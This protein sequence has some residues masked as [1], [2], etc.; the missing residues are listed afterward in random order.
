MHFHVDELEIETGQNWKGDRC[1]VV[2]RFDGTVHVDRFGSI[3]KID[4]H[5]WPASTKPTDSWT[6]A[7]V[8]DAPPLDPT[9]RLWDLVVPAIQ[10]QYAEQ[11]AEAAG[12][13]RDNE[14]VKEADEYTT[15]W[16]AGVGDVAP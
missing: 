5:A 9:R 7:D 2:C 12:I 13:R 16:V 14:R 3:T 15:A 8:A 1:Y 6:W 10:R 4:W 11:I